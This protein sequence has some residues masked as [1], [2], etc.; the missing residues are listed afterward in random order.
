MFM[1]RD[2]AIFCA[3]AVMS[4]M[5]SA[6][7]EA[8]PSRVAVADGDDAIM[9]TDAFLYCRECALPLLLF[10]RTPAGI[11]LPTDIR[12]VILG[13]PFLFADFTAALRR[14]SDTAPM[15]SMPPVGD[16]RPLLRWDPLR[17][18]VLCGSEEI[19][20]TPR[21]ADVFAVLFAASPAPVSREELQ[22]GFARTDGNGADV[23]IS[24]LRRK[25]AALPLSAQIHSVRGK[26]YA[27][28]VQSAASQTEESRMDGASE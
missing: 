20:L 9:Q 7:C 11:T 26:G 22:K 19:L 1:Q 4:R 3:D 21:E 23:Y 8:H 18:A 27:L 15:P 2:T 14:L 13:R 25:L 17:R 16:S 28:L 10:S 12:G 24:Y 5:L 6:L